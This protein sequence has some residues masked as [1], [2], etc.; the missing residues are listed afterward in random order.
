LVDLQTDIYGSQAK[1]QWLLDPTLANL[2]T[3]FRFQRRISVDLYICFFF[4]VPKL[5]I[6]FQKIKWVISYWA[7]EIISGI[8]MY[9]ID[10]PLVA[11]LAIWV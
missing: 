2:Y 10:F 9:Y 7:L 6:G 3:P 4:N 5:K 8:A 1:N 11:K